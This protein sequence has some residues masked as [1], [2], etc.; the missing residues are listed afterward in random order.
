MVIDYG[1]NSE[2]PTSD[3]TREEASTSSSPPQSIQ[4]KLEM[5]RISQHILLTIHKLCMSNAKHDTSHSL[6]NSRCC[7]LERRVIN[8]YIC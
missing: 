5:P 2:D 6:G 4:E 1:E 8:F 7:S 3:E